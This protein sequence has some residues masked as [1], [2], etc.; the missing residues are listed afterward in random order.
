M[1]FEF[2]FK[3]CLNWEN[4]NSS[5]NKTNSI[6]RCTSC[7]NS[8][9]IELDSEYIC[10]TCGISYGCLIDETAEWKM[11]GS[12]DNRS[13]DPTR[14]GA[15]RNPIL[16]ET[17]LSTTIAYSNNPVYKKLRQ[18]NIWISQP[19]AERMAKNVF[20]ILTQ[21]G[22]ANGLTHNIIE[23]SHRLFYEAIN[24]QSR[25][26]DH[27]SSRGDFRDGLIAAC[28]SQA[29]KE[30]NVAR[31]ASEIAKM[32]EIDYSDVTRG[33]NLFNELMKNST[34]VDLSKDI[35]KFTDFLD[36]Y[37]YSLGLNEEQNKTIK[38]FTHKVYTK[39]ILSKNTPESMLCG[40]IFFVSIMHNYG[41]TRQDIS[42]KC[43]TSIPTINKVYD[44]LLEFTHELI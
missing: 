28:L 3:D 29:C 27:T 19:Y 38:K 36:R 44:R 34:Y 15:P 24:E 35:L 18:Q 21:I 4:N 37:C 14:C 23:Y 33:K 12:E 6:N 5:I 40:C 8:K 41:I 42:I 11:Y 1:E 9:I 13:G 17:S 7:I 30:F 25:N 32:C 16:I 39:K 2:N 22:N 43:G 26:P 10:D 31:S 20:N